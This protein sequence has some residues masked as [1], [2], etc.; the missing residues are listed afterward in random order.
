MG[1]SG[2]CWIGRGGVGDVGFDFASCR[3]K[4]KKRRKRKEEKAVSTG[5][6][7]DMRWM[8]QDDGYVSSRDSNERLVVVSWQR[9]IDS[10]E[11]MEIVYLALW[12]GE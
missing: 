10:G 12:K 9:D 5:L 8:E 3:E 7:V 11:V 4:R 1:G 6:I 2:V